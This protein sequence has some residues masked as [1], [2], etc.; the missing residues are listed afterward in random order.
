MKCLDINNI[1]EKSIKKI[2]ALGLNNGHTVDSVKKVSMAAANLFQ[3]LKA[4]Y[5][6][7][8]YQKPKI[9]LEQKKKL[10]LQDLQNE[11]L[12]LSKSEKKSA[13]STSKL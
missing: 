2:D 3:F 9:L 4:V 13:K 5:D 6:L 1:K 7:W 10:L 12:N 8:N 11:K